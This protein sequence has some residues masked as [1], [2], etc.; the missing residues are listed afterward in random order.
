MPTPSS[1]VQEDQLAYKKR[2]ITISCKTMM[3]LPCS[4]SNPSALAHLSGMDA[5]IK[6]LR[7][8]W[9]FFQNPALLVHHKQC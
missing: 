3:V 9:A 8:C 4:V 2:V 7:H 1:S 5:V 6:L